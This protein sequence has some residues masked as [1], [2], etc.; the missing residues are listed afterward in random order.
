[1]SNKILSLAVVVI[2]LMTFSFSVSAQE[3]NDSSGI[4]NASKSLTNEQAQVIFG[5]I[6]EQ[7]LIKYGEIYLFDNFSFEL[8]NERIEDGRTLI[9]VNIYAYMT[10]ARHPSDSPFIKGMVKSL[11]EIDDEVENGLGK[12]R[13]KGYIDEIETLYYKKPDYSVFSYSIAIKDNISRALNAND[14]QY[15]LF[16]RTDVTAEEIILEPIGDL[17][18]VEDYTLA[19]DTMPKTNIDKTSIFPYE[20][21]DDT[22]YY[23]IYGDSTKEPISKEFIGLFINGSII[24]N[25]NLI[26]ENDRTLLPVRNIAESLGAKVYWDSKT[27]K[28]TIIDAENTIELFI[29]NKNAK[30]NGKEFVL[31][32]VPK[33]FNNYTYVPVRFVAEALNAKVNYFDGKD[34]TKPHIVIRMPHVMISRYPDNVKTISKEE[35]IERVR[36]QLII[37]FKKK[38][39]EFIPLAENEKPSREDD[40]AILRDVITNLKIESENDRYYVIPVM[41]DFWV[42]KYTGDVY[43]FYNG[44]V[45]TINI[46]NPYDEDALSFPG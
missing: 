44:L 25:S 1:M 18:K 34:I 20:G 35:A 17:D 6:K 9:D 39:G 14:I 45:M 37:A 22:E 7:I 10:L 29:D 32:V 46:F 42:D 23:I 30:I 4:K 36:E 3:T 33:I 24:K 8:K 27:R 21:R 40:K 43:T 19:E 16:Y 41:Y 28:V 15:E 5:D 31:D 11:S 38:F 13:I 26:T 12:D 2:M